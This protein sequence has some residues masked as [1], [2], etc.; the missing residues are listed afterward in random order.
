MPLTESA[1]EAHGARLLA[2]KSE[3]GITRIADITQLDWIGIPVATAFRPAG[4]TL[5]VAQGKGKTRQQAQLSALLEAVEFASAENLRPDLLGVR[6]SDLDL[7]YDLLDIA[8][9]TTSLLSP[10]APLD[11]VHGQTVRGNL[12]VTIPYDRTRVFSEDTP[13]WRPPFVHSDS[14]GLAAGFDRPWAL[15]H[16]ML[17][18]LERSAT[19]AATLHPDQVLDLDLSS[20][21]SGWC[22]DFIE[23]F[24]KQEGFVSVRYL[25][26]AD[27]IHTFKAAV[28]S[29]DFPCMA[30]GVASDRSKEKALSACLAEAAQ[31]RLTAISGVRDDLPDIYAPMRTG[32]AGK[33][34]PAAVQVPWSDLPDDSPSGED[35]TSF[36][37]RTLTEPTGQEPVFRV[38]HEDPD[39]VVVRVIGFGFYS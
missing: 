11:W 37:I 29:E 12:P 5:S 34:L 30:I 6:A 3:W 38:L 7:P 10:Q 33:P 15:D 36:L 19:R 24:I 1:L 35:D 8:S 28:W 27:G 31:S 4:R 2:R 20:V 23:R 16:A 32:L 22:T 21:A 39:L 13:G 18:I 9:P 14:T 17:E 25:P 26:S